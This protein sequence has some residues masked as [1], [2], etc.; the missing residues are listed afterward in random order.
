MRAYCMMGVCMV[1]MWRWEDNL[2]ELVLS[3]HVY[4]ESRDQI[5]VTRLSFQEPLPTRGP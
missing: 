1:C 5:Q 3:F 2:V 4:M